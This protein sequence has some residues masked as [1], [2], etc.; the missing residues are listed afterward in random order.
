MGAR[1][2]KVAWV[3]A[4]VHQAITSA[5]GIGGTDVVTEGED[6]D[7]TDPDIALDDL[8]DVEAPT[9]AD[10]DAL[11]WDD[12][13]GMWVPGAPASAS[14]AQ[15][16]VPVMVDNPEFVTTTGNAVYLV[17]VDGSGAPVVA[18]VTL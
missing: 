2:V 4:R 10:G 1:L 14:T 11:V 18:L 3:R 17:L 16:Y 15:A 8:S 13:A 7:S 5:T 6:W 9:P 12:G